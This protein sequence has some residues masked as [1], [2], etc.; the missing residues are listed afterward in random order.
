MQCKE[1]KNRMA[2]TERKLKSELVKQTETT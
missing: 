2:G 1:N